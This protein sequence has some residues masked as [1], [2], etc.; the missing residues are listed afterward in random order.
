MLP[1]SHERPQKH[2]PLVAM[3]PD[4]A[5]RSRLARIARPASRLAALTG[6]RPAR[7]G[8][9]VQARRA[10]RARRYPSLLNCAG[11]FS[12]VRCKRVLALFPRGLLR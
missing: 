5:I 12:I 6:C 1:R 2:H 8:L 3:G 11:A 4:S 9:A 10:K 7:Q